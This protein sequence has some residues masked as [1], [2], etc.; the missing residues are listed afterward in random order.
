MELFTI[1][2][3]EIQTAA[4]AFAN[5]QYTSGYIWTAGNNGT[6]CMSL[7]RTSGLAMFTPTSTNCALGCYYFCGYKSKLFW[8]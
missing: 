4:I 3:N 1:E 8:V 7:R 2:S 6:D 5:T